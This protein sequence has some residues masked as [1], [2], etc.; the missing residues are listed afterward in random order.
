MV[1]VVR[2]LAV[3]VVVALGCAGCGRGDAQDGPAGT[4]TPVPGL[5]WHPVEGADPVV[6]ET[7]E[8]LALRADL[9]AAVAARSGTRVRVSAESFAVQVAQVLIDVRHGVSGNEV[10]AR[11]ASD[12]LPDEVRRYLAQ[13]VDSIQQSRLERHLDPAA[14]AW[15]R[16]R[17]VGPADAPIRVETE[18]AAVMVSEPIGFRK[19]YRTRYD[20]V[21]EDGRWSLIGFSDGSF[22][23]KTA[24]LTPAER[25]D[26]LPGPGWR[27]VPPG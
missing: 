17:L 12:D 1:R 26:F 20:V 19:W 2:W 22:G 23:P 3:L 10:L 5:T 9:D 7:P 24:P 14:G 16:S 27:F 4:F 8:P 15:I 25:R 6:D 11:I 21:W 18:L 13:D